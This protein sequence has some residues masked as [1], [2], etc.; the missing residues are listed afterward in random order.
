MKIVGYASVLVFASNNAAAFVPGPIATG[1]L[2]TSGPVQVCL[3]QLVVGTVYV[4]PKHA[5]F[6][7]VVSHGR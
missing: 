7:F 4:H 3:A 6:F 2:R 1:L 5:V